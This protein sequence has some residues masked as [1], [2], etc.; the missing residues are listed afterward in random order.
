MF[1]VGRPPAAATT[2]LLALLAL[3][4]TGGG[5]TPKE[6]M[7]SAAKRI[8]EALQLKPPKRQADLA[9]VHVPDFLLE[10][11]RQQTGVEVDTSHFKLP[12]YR[13]GYSDSSTSYKGSVVRHS[14]GLVDDETV[15]VFDNFSPP[16]IDASIETAVLRVFWRPDE[17][18]SLKGSFRVRASDLVSFNSDKDRQITSLEDVARLHQR[19]PR[20]DQGWYDF[21]VTGAVLRWTRLRPEKRRLLLE[22]GPVTVSGEHLAAAIER[23]PRA[24]QSLHDRGLKLENVRGGGGISKAPR[25]RFTDAYLLIFSESSFGRQSRQRRAA[26]RSQMP[27]HKRRYKNQLRQP[28]QRYEMYVD[29]VEVGWK[30]WIFAP[31]GFHAY[32]CEGACRYRK[33]LRGGQF[34][35]PRLLL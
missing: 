5:G 33:H 23:S 9:D 18:S 22:T 34:F 7:E 25:G 17:G 21:D 32:H 31:E 19:D 24:L 11:Y 4:P 1:F 16:A 35:S 27:K 26:K 15:V 28:C 20:L 10:L 14:K 2:L 13:T 29:F 12:G 3:A 8:L 6:A 30:N